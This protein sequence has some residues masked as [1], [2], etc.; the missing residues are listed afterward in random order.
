MK[1][2]TFDE[3]THKI[4]PIEPTLDMVFATT[5]INN[6]LDNEDLFPMLRA[7]IKAAPEY[8]EPEESI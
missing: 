7:A 3:T 6:S 4:V 8:Q 1:T 2:A 5:H